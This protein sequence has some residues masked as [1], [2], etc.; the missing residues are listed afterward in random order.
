MVLVLP[1]REVLEDRAPEGHE[2]VV[3]LRLDQPAPRVVE[4]ERLPVLALMVGQQRLSVAQVALEHLV[5]R[6]PGHRRQARLDEV[7][8]D[9]R[10]EAR[11]AARIGAVV[12]PR[13]PVQEHIR[14]RQDHRVAHDRPAVEHRA[15][16][17]GARRRARVVGDGD[18]GI[19]EAVPDRLGG[20]LAVLRAREA[21][22]VVAEEDPVAALKRAEQ[23]ARP[24]RAWVAV[25]PVP[26]RRGRAS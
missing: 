22:G 7:V 19:A 15:L 10:T 4:R 8:V 11:H 20:P 17:R 5:P 1:V 23:R 18:A 25:P 13:D 2:A 3:V 14:A 6:Q 24:D 16:V 21:R 9:V 26:S 12:G